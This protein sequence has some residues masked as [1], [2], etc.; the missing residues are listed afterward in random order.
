MQLRRS[1]VV[2]LAGAA[3]VAAVAPASAGAVSKRGLYGERY[4]EFIALR[5]SLPDVT[6]TV[7]NTIAFN[8]CPAAWW[9][10]LEASAVSAQLGAFTT[11]MNG[12]RFWVIDRASSPGIGEVIEVGG[13]QLA[14]VAQIKLTTPSDLVPATYTERTIL[15][16]N[17]WRWRAKRRV[18]ELISD[19]GAV[20]MMQAYS[21]I[22]DPDQRRDELADLGDRLDLP[23]GWSFRTRKL[24]RPFVLDAGGAATI[25]QDELQNTY[26]RVDQVPPRRASRTGLAQSQYPTQFTKFKY[27]LS[28]GKAKFEGKI[29]SAKSSCVNGRKVK[30]Y[31]KHDGDE[32]KLG[33]DKTNSKGK[34][35]IGAGTPPVKDGKY[36]AEVKEKTVGSDDDK[37]CL[38]ATSGSVKFS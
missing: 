38:S 37:T 32:K 26:Q 12:P 24:K 35:S 15:R 14:E 3:L 28:N 30:L 21:Q 34:F 13:E 16:E 11:L 36:Y 4:C 18:Y 29:D 22:V 5:G 19:E 6:A 8:D 10:S 17:Q 23:E 9:D 7:Y 1:V 20:Y 27:E 33:D 31:R 25:I 2:L